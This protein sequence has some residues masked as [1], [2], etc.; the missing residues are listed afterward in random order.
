MF[1]NTL[2]ADDK[3][4]LLNRYNLL[5]HVQ[6]QLYQKQKSFSA[7]TFFAIWKS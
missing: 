2:S 4:S 7:F 1:V 3:Y 5:Q 6:M